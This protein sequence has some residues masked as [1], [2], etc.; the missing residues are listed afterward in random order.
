MKFISILVFLVASIMLQA[1]PS[2]NTLSGLFTSKNKKSFYTS[3]Q[4]DGNGKVVINDMEQYDYFERNDSIIILIDKTFFILQKQKQNELKGISDGIA[5]D[6]LKSNNKVFQYAENNPIKS[7]RANALSAYFDINFFDLMEHVVGEEKDY[8]TL[9]GELKVKNEQLCQDNLDL[10]CIQ[11]FVMTLTEDMGGLEAFL[12]TTS[13]V[14]KTKH[15]PTLEQ[16]GNKIIA[17]GNAEGYGL[18]SQYYEL[19]N[20]PIKAQSFRE[21]GLE[22]GCK[23]CLELEM[24]QIL[25]NLQEAEN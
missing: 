12:S 6:V 18:L 15:N 13:P 14:L 3:F 16:L 7:K 19:I 17:M 22:N 23:L 5:G 1:Q 4:F 2:N 25:N 11:V 10:A 21:E 24:N 8:N 20:E 9:I